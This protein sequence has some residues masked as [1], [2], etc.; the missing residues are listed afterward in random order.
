MWYAAVITDPQKARAAR[1]AAVEAAHLKKG[2]LPDRARALAEQ[3]ESAAHAHTEACAAD[4]AREREPFA[5][6]VGDLW[7]DGAFALDCPRGLP[8]C[9]NC[10]DPDHADTC[11]ADG[12]CPLCGRRGGHGVASDR[13]LKE[14][15]VILHALPQRPRDDERWDRDARRFRAA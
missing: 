13:V 7:H 8:N 15:G 5:L 1:L 12:H 14:K 4:C 2:V 11:R 9:R 3:S 10:G 6:Q